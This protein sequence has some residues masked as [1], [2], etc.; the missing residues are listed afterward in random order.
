MILHRSTCVSEEDEINEQ[1]PLRRID[2][3]YDAGN[4]RL[5][6]QQQGTISI[7]DLKGAYTQPLSWVLA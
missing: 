2:I 3:T 4:N 7:H 5:I 6:L 1:L